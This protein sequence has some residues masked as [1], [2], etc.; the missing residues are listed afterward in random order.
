MHMAMRR[1]PPLMRATTVINPGRGAAIRSRRGGAR[2]HKT[3]QKKDDKK[4]R[5]RA[6]GLVAF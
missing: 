3:N 1:S 2:N 6:T 4:P 5:G